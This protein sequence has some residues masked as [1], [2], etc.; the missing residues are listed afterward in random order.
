MYYFTS[1]LHLGHEN[2]IKYCNRPFNNVEEMNKEII[3]NWN[4]TVNDND[5]VIVA[6]DFSF[7]STSMKGNGT[8]TEYKEWSSLLKGNKIFIKGNHD[9]NNNNKSKI[10]SIVLK[11]SKQDIFVTHRPNDIVL[12]YDLYLVGHVHNTWKHK[13]INDGYRNNLLINVGV[14]VW[15]FK[16]IRID[17]ILQY[18][19]RNKL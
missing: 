6:G 5:T 11:I 13:I 19:A 16:P 18:I 3:Y 12:G 8:K 14:D 9:S 2:I 10:S 7:F 15:D 17:N 4:K 1:D